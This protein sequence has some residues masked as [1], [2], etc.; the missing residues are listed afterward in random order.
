MFQVSTKHC[1]TFSTLFSR[2]REKKIEDAQRRSVRQQRQEPSSRQ[3]RKALRDRCG[4]QVIPSLKYFYR[5]VASFHIAMIMICYQN[6]DFS[7]PEEVVGV[8][9]M[10]LLMVRPTVLVTPGGG[11]VM[12]TRAKKWTVD[13]LHWE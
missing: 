13:W 10:V 9:L 11:E 4:V 2:H 8:G 1:S 3:S 6:I 5:S 12:S 7:V